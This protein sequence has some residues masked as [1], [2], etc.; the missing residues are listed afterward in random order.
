VQVLVE[1]SNLSNLADSRLIADPAYR[2]RVAD[3][4]VDALHLYYGESAAG[5][6]SSRLVTSRGN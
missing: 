6:P 2:Q 4:Y 5:P 3:A 1:V